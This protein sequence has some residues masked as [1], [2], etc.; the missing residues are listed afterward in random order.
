MLCFNQNI[1]LIFIPE[2]LLELYKNFIVHSHIELIYC[3]SLP[4]WKWRA[5]FYLILLQHTYADS[6]YYR[7]TFVL[8]D[9]VSFEI[10]RCDFNFI[11]AIVNFKS[12]LIEFDAYLIVFFGAYAWSKLQYLLNHFL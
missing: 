5:E 3:I 4:G 1:F 10:M 6:R 9:L 12:L 2:T 8:R 7:V 11:P